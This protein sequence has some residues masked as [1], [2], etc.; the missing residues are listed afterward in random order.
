M[1]PTLLTTALFYLAGQVFAQKHELGLT[2]GRLIENDHGLVRSQAGTALQANYGYRFWGNSSVAVFGE[3]HLLAS[4]LRDVS[5]ALSATRDYS[6]LYLTPGVRV[7]LNSHGRI[8]PYGVVG[9]GYALYEQSTH[10]IGGQP[11]PAP[12]HIQRGALMYGAGVDVPIAR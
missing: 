8:Q 1:K 2:I 7:K 10:N 11:N 9:G 5:G 3:F 6:S 12:R 4:P